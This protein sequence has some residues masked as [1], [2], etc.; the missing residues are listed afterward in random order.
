MYY[1]VLIIV[2]LENIIY[3]QNEFDYFEKLIR[4]YRKHYRAL[5]FN[6][7]IAYN[8]VNVL[9]LSCIGFFNLQLSTLLIS[10]HFNVIML[11]KPS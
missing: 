7:T 2:I 8:S 9:F 1:Y 4:M 6:F 11:S 10:Y 5:I 3:K